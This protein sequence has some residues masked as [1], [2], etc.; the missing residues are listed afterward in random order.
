MEKFINFTCA[1]EGSDW[2]LDFKDSLAFLSSPLE[3]LTENLKCKVM[4][5]QSFKFIFLIPHY[6]ADFES[7]HIANSDQV[8]F[9]HTFDF[10]RTRFKDTPLHHFKLLL[11]KGV[12]PYDYI[13]SY[14]VLKEKK[15]P[16]FDSF[17][18]RLHQEYI[19][20][21]DYH[22]A[23]KVSFSLNHCFDKALP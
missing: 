19:T 8:Y 7:K 6:Q 2:S 1:V 18:N 16:S 21:A 14:Q 13:T 11:R 15:L 20:W 17:Y 9:K 4:T 22:H 10:F 5:S 3:K 12:F 23:E